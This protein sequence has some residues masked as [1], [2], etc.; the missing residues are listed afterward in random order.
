MQVLI[1]DD[2]ESRQE[3]Y[4]VAWKNVS[5]DIFP[6]YSII[7]KGAK[8][9]YEIYYPLDK[10][11]TIDQLLLPVLRKPKTLESE[12]TTEKNIRSIPRIIETKKDE[13]PEIDIEELRYEANLTITRL[14]ETC[15]DAWEEIKLLRKP[16]YTGDYEADYGIDESNRYFKENGVH[17]YA[18]QIATLIQGLVKYAKYD[19]DIFGDNSINLKVVLRDYVSIVNTI[20][21]SIGMD[22]VN[23]LHEL[24]TCAEV[25]ISVQPEPEYESVVEPYVLK[26]SGATE[27][28]DEPP[29]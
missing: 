9:Y 15:R 27:H 28:E 21:D 25:V 11:T 3:L 24:I 5:P 19:K 1:D 17:Q 8:T 20:H 4:F 26:S 18:D 29:Q 13:E 10:I 14:A 2:S 23:N 12:E 16:K 6:R 7:K 22:A